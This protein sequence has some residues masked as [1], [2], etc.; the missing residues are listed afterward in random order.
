MEVMCSRAV[1]CAMPLRVGEPQVVEI[2]GAVHFG[3]SHNHIV[4]LGR[5]TPEINN[6]CIE[7][8]NQNA[9]R[10]GCL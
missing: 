3:V 8:V 7:N 9:I 5:K 10:V 4:V 6:Y 2:F 1:C